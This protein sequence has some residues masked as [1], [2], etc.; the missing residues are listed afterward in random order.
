M[1]LSWVYDDAANTLKLYVDG[2]LQTT[3]TA[4]VTQSIGLSTQAFYIGTEIPAVGHWFNGMI[5]DLRLYDHALSEM[6]IADAMKG[7]GPNLMAASTPNPYDGQTDVRR[8]EV[9]RWTPGKTIGMHDVYIGTS[10]ACQG[11]WTYPCLCSHGCGVGW[12]AEL[13]TRPRGGQ[14]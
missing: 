8:D 14:A 10:C 3:A 13:A 11:L 5:D 9:L 6:E 4:T 1:H 7:I 2:A 12:G